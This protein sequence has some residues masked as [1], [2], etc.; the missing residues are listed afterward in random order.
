MLQAY[1]DGGN[2]I[3]SAV[4]ASK[5]GFAFEEVCDRYQARGKH[6]TNKIKVVRAASLKESKK[7]VNSRFCNISSIIKP[8]K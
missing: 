3:G 6:S 7:G 1:F 4:T 8:L 5:N 2:T